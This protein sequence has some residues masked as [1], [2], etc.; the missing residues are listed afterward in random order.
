[1]RLQDVLVNAERS[2]NS[3]DHLMRVVYPLSNDKK[4]ILRVL[5]RVY[6]SAIF[7][8]SFLLKY[9]HLTKKIKLSKNTDEN[10]KMFYSISRDYGLNENEIEVI[11]KLIFI[12]KKHKESGFEFSRKSKVIIMS[13]DLETFELNEEYMKSFILT[14]KRLIS[15]IRMKICI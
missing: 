8:I 7:A 14:V 10:I 9:E 11:K 12:G 3:A 5:E 4:V 6:D 1:M 2:I 13:D 15:I